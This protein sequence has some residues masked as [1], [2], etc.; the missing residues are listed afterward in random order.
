MTAI[1]TNVC[2]KVL[3]TGL[4]VHYKKELE[5]SFG[6]YAEVYDGTDNTSVSRVNVLVCVQ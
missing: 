5:L 1:N 4:K 3:F 2:P 6:D